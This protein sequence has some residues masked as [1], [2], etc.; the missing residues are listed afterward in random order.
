GDSRHDHGGK[1]RANSGIVFFRVAP[2]IS[3][4]ASLSAVCTRLSC[5][6][7]L[8]ITMSKDEEKLSEE[9]TFH[10]AAATLVASFD[11]A[12]RRLGR[13]VAA[14]IARWSLRVFFLEAAAT[15]QRDVV[16]AGDSLIAPRHLLRG[17]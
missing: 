11:D 2:S 1:T 17:A 14:I 8:D 3:F 7:M 12:C 9:I 5:A 6:D 4:L 16:R 15:T 10:R 13:V